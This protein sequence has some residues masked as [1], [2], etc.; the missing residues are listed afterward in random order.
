MILSINVGTIS[1]KVAFNMIKGCKNKNY[2]EDNAAMVWERF[3][4]KY[5]PTSALS[6]FKTE[7]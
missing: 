6:L 4:N 1:I 2:K 5:E 3:E 7:K